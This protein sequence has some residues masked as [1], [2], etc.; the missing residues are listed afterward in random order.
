MTE[1]TQASSLVQIQVNMYQPT[2][3]L[4]PS[5]MSKAVRADK[6]LGFHWLKIVNSWLARYQGLEYG[7]RYRKTSN[8]RRTSAGNKIV[9]HSDV[10]GASPVGAAPT[11]S[12][13]ST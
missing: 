11:T 1:T 6:P 9:D 13:F 2:R 5:N 7:P 8:I 4:T 3:L 10:V 12:S